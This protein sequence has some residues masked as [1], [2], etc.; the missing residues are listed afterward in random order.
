MPEYTVKELAEICGVSETAIKKQLAKLNET[1]V[2][3]K[4]QPSQQ[5]C[6]AIFRHYGIE[7]PKVAELSSDNCVTDETSAT[8]PQPVN[9][10][11]STDL[12]ATLNKT[13]ELLQ[14][15]LESK[16]KQIDKLQQQIDVLLETNRSM[17]AEKTLQAAVEAKPILLE[18]GTQTEEQKDGF[19]TRVKKVFRP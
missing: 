17:S 1:K 3:G 13:V 4:W 18:Q 14:K 15:E 19:W 8:T 2:A 12:L 10:T 7:V 5:G 16:D 9:D 6:D 11:L